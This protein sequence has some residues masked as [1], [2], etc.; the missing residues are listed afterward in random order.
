MNNR[1]AKDLTEDPLHPKIQFP[2]IIQCSKCYSGTNNTFNEEEVVN[3]L[4][5]YY[6]NIEGSAELDYQRKKQEEKS[7]LNEDNSQNTNK[8]QVQQPSEDDLK[9]IMDKKLA[10]T[11]IYSS[12]G[13]TTGE[14]IF[15][16]LFS[17]VTL[18]LVFYGFI[19]LRGNRCRKKKHAL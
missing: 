3:Y 10:E 5:K 6:S 1:L 15:L 7:R 2:S 16:Y 11:E 4:I 17:I 14:M 13:F 19:K 9:K 8:L 12:K 18:M